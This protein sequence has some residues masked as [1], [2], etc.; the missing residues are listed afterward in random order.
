[1][2]AAPTMAAALTYACPNLIIIRPAHAPQAFTHLAMAPV[3]ISMSPLPSS[4]LQ[5]TSVVSTSTAPI[6]QRPWCLLVDVCWLHIIY[7]FKNALCNHIFN[8][9]PTSISSIL[10]CERQARP[11]HRIGL[12]FLDRQFYLHIISWHLQN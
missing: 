12:C 1:M 5:N 8:K 6:T 9:I 10:L 3:A 11:S 7:F 2:H 4:Q